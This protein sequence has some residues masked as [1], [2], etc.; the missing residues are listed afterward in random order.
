RVARS[1]DPH[2]RP[3]GSDWTVQQV[4][5]HMVSVTHRYQ[6]V[7]QGRDFHRATYPRELD[8]INQVELEAAMAPIPALVDQ[9]DALAPVIDTVFDAC[10][11]DRRELKFHCGAIVSGIMGQTNWLGELALHG[12]DIARAVKAPWEMH[13]RD[14]LLVLRGPHSIEFSGDGPSFLP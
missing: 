7:A 13:E 4:V 8:L 2:A 3:P 5:A 6:A 12:Q 14:M 11:N 10:T 9:L 1:A